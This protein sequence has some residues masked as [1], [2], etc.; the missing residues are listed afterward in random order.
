MVCSISIS[1]GKHSSLKIFLFRWNLEN[2]T[3]YYFRIFDPYFENLTKINFY[4][5]IGIYQIPDIRKEILH[6]SLFYYL[7]IQ[8]R[9]LKKLYSL[10]QGIFLRTLILQ[11]NHNY[12]WTCPLYMNLERHLLSPKICDGV[13]DHIFL[14]LILK[15]NRNVKQRPFNVTYSLKGRINTSSHWW[16]FGWFLIIS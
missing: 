4:T 11:L 13:I 1:T 7:E 5:T 12:R 15:L 16:S 3:N 9:E 14:F 6:K 2:F 10:L 8:K